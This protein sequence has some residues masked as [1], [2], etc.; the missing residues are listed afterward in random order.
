MKTFIDY[1]TNYKNIITESEIFTDLHNLKPNFDK[2]DIR[3]LNNL[4]KKLKDSFTEIAT[5]HNLMYN[6]S[7]SI[8]DLKTSVKEVTEDKVENVVN[9]VMAISK[10]SK[11]SDGVKNYFE[12]V[13][14]GNLSYGYPSFWKYKIYD[15]LLDSDAN[16]IDSKLD[17]ICSTAIAKIPESDWKFVYDLYKQKG[18]SDKDI[19]TVKTLLLKCYIVDSSFSRYAK[20]YNYKFGWARVGTTNGY[21]NFWGLLSAI[22]EQKWIIYRGVTNTPVNIQL[23]NF[24]KD[25]YGDS[26][27]SIE[28]IKNF[29]DKNN[30]MYSLLIKSPNE[31]SVEFSNSA[32]YNYDKIEIMYN[33]FVYTYG[34]STKFT[35]RYDSN[36]KIIGRD[37]K[38]MLKKL[39]AEYY[40]KWFNS[41]KN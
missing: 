32:H 21:Y 11:F 22:L 19:D 28:E 9:S 18:Y 26:V 39:N 10:S 5:E 37:T 3:Y 17:K 7:K 40:G 30:N 15:V 1:L 36:N 4:L 33:G 6:A 16:N 8:I 13:D 27:L 31:F 34:L 2:I 29:I 41:Y 24:K 20:F 35:F 38:V 25:A 14:T 23:S 12:N